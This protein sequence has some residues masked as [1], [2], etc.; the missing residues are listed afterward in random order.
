MESN[1]AV[2][3]LYFCD[4][5]FGEF[6]VWLQEKNDEFS[7]S[8]MS[9]LSCIKITVFFQAPPLPNVLRQVRLMESSLIPISQKL[10]VE[11]IQINAV[12]VLLLLLYFLHISSY[13]FENF[14]KS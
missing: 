4:R 7:A 10:L 2:T 8:N 13:L 6:H 14:T 9:S 5:C 12:L 11:L 3:L 1:T